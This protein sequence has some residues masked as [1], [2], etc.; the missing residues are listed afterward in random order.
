MTNE[1]AIK[2][3]DKGLDVG[4]QMSFLTVDQMNEAKQKAIKA[5]EQQIGLADY[6]HCLKHRLYERNIDNPT[7]FQELSMLMDAI[8]NIMRQNADLKVRF[9]HDEITSN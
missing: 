8:E 7:E 4:N 1:E 5:L 3:I 9:A 6:K 2:I